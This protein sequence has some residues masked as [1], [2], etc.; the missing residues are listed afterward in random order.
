MEKQV[1]VTC[2]VA[3]GMWVAASVFVFGG[4]VLALW[5][6]ERFMASA[7][8]LMAQ[9]LGLSAAAATV[10]VRQMFKTQNLMMREVFLLGRES[11]GNPP[12]RSMR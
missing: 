7:I 5:A 8:A 3:I 4:T 10:T 11:T 1:S 9:G 2:V 6:G 12:V